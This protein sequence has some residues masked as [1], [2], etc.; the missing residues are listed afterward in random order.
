MFI[1]Y[2]T[3]IPSSASVE[4][5]FSIAGLFETPRRI[6]LSEAMFEKL[7]LLKLIHGTV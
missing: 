4:R 1:R 7:T 6:K 3:A 2:D 5:L